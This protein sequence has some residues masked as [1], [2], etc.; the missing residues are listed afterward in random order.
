MDTDSLIKTIPFLRTVIQMAVSGVW[1]SINLTSTCEY[2][3]LVRISY[4]KFLIFVTFRIHFVIFYFILFLCY[5]IN[6][7]VGN[8]YIEKVLLLL[9]NNLSKTSKWQKSLRQI[10]MFDRNWKRVFVRLKLNHTKWPSSFW[11][12]PFHEMKR[13]SRTFLWN[14]WTII[15]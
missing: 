1:I 3:F 13:S 9:A 8:K 11:V 7:C 4:N 14:W 12:V 2:T 5:F 10:C 6:L 15:N